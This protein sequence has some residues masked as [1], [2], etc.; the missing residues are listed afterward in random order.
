MLYLFY[1]LRQVEPFFFFGFFD[2]C[3]PCIILHDQAFALMQPEFGWGKVRIA[4]SR[5]DDAQKTIQSH[6]NSLATT[7]PNFVSSESCNGFSVRPCIPPSL[8]NRSLAWKEAEIC[9]F[10]RC[11]IVVSKLLIYREVERDG[12]GWR[13]LLLKRLLTCYRELGVHTSILPNRFHEYY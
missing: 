3:L 10:Q 12:T 7:N 11:Q 1:Y 4:S 2:P 5:D 6:F 8:W 13:I 9:L